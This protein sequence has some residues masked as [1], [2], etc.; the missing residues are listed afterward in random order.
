MYIINIRWTFLSHKIYKIRVNI[1]KSFYLNL[2]I[3]IV[4]T[5]K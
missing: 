4:H 2:Y 5:L 1:N 3:L